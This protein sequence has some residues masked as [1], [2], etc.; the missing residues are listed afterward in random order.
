MFEPLR[1]FAEPDEKWFGAP[2]FD[3]FTQGRS[4]WRAV[5]EFA[6]SMAAF[7]AA[8]GVI[9]AIRSHLGLG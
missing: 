2:R 1:I 7:V 5:A 6:L 3:S 9:I 8:A 4:C